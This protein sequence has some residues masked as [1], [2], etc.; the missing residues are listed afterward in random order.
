MFW[1]EQKSF[2]KSQ[3]SEVHWH[4][5]TKSKEEAH[6]K[7]DIAAHSTAAQ[8]G[9]AN[10]SCSLFTAA[11]DYYPFFEVV[12]LQ[13]SACL[14]EIISH[15]QDHQHHFNWDC[16]LGFS[17][18]W[19]LADDEVQVLK[20]TNNLSLPSLSDLWT[21]QTDRQTSAAHHTLLP[22][23]FSADADFSEKE[24]KKEKEKERVP[25]EQ[26]NCPF[27]S[28]GD[29][30]DQCRPLNIYWRPTNLGELLTITT[31]ITPFSQSS[32]RWSAMRVAAGI[33]PPSSIASQP[34]FLVF[35]FAK[36]QWHRRWWLP[37]S[38]CFCCCWTVMNAVCM[39]EFWPTENR[40]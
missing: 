11:A 38:V 19:W 22:P 37:F 10:C 4:T 30:D 21:V 20:Q 27:S 39:L 17:C 6:K 33:W 40:Q 23:P 7:R 3:E 15:R 16:R 36:K 35:F 25:I 14:E 32:I 12:K 2:Q 18:L 1:K 9:I 34:A 8:W 13:T 5:G 29:D 24:R 31:T 28:G 26:A